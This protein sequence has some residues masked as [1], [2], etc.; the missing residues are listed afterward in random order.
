MEFKDLHFPEEK[1]SNNYPAYLAEMKNRLDEFPSGTHDRMNLLP[2]L[3]YLMVCDTVSWG[4][5]R[6]YDPQIK[7]HFTP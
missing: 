3:E 5:Q 6:G 1:Y 2:C 7:L 4:P